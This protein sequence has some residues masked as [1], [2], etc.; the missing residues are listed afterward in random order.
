MLGGREVGISNRT[1][2]TIA[3][4]DKLG[5]HDLARDLQLLVD[6]Y[7]CRNPYCDDELVELGIRENDPKKTI[8]VYCG[9]CIKYGIARVS[10]DLEEDSGNSELSNP[11]GS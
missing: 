10:L 7:I 1:V 2:K 4:I 3:N 9:N 8:I 5:N 6:S 11:Q